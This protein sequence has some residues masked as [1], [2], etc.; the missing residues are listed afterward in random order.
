MSS[1]ARIKVFYFSGGAQLRGIS[2]DAGQLV[3]A[4]MAGGVMGF[5]CGLIPFRAGMKRKQNG[6]AIGAM[7]ACVVVGLVGGC[8]LALPTAFVFKWIIAG[9]GE[10]KTEEHGGYP[11]FEARSHP[12]RRSAI[13]REYSEPVVQHPYTILGTAVVCN[14]CRKA[15][16]KIDGKPPSECPHC[17]RRFEAQPKAKPK[18]IPWARREKPQTSEDDLIPLERA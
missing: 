1:P 11:G 10:V 17:H 16:S 13:D 9:I 7:I 18:P 8:I 12:G 15:C 5:A 14:R 2:M 3:I 6:L 4:A